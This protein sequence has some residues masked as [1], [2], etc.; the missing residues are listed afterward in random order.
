MAKLTYADKTNAVP[1]TNR[2]TQATAEDFNEIKSSVNTLYDGTN[3]NITEEVFPVKVGTQFVDSPLS[4]DVSESEVVSSTPINVESINNIDKIEFDITT[5]FGPYSAG[6]FTYDLTTKGHVA[7]TGYADVRNNVGREVHI[8]VYNA[9]ASPILNGTAVSATGESTN[10]IPNVIPTTADN[11]LI[12]LG[13]VGVATMEIPAGQSGLVTRIGIV[14]DMD[15][16][17]LST[18]PGFIYVDGSG[19]YTHTRTLYPDFRLVIGGVLK[20]GVLDGIIYV[21]PRYIP[22]RSASRSYTFTSADAGAGTHYRAGFYDWSS[23]SATLTQASLSTTHGTANVTRAAHV[24]IVA[25]G[26]GTV[27]TG[28][29]GIQVTGTLDSETGT[30]TAAQTAIITDDI[31]TLT[32]DTMIESVEK[33]SGI[34]TISLYVVS[35]TPTT[36]SVSFNYGFSKYEDISNINGTVTAFTAEWEAGANDTEFN[37]QLKHHKADG[38]TYA[39]SGFIAGNGNICERLVDQAIN[40]N[41]AIGKEG[42]YKRVDLDTYL[43]SSGP[44]GIVIEIT[45]GANN[46]IRSMDMHVTA[47]SEELF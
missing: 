24:G 28:Q 36:Y 3:D 44:E 16:S 31:T 34:V 15:T 7:D 8:E 43:A 37:I 22:R 13:F 32:A 26:P 2:P 6:Q 19:N 45:T 21:S 46:T 47:F 10:E 11:I 30:Q 38:W 5:A 41:L 18:T 33:F 12:V 14:R 29:V 27:D 1:V 23:T 17:G 4:Y 25:S 42:A 9:T 20:V 39:A 40:S 35:G